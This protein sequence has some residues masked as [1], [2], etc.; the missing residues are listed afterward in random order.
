MLLR[1]AADAVAV[2]GLFVRVFRNSSS[3]RAVM[4]KRF[5]LRIE[6]ISPL[7]SS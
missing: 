6:P 1:Y 5:P 7:L 2:I 4:M 3:A